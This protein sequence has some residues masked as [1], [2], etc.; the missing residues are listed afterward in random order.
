MKLEI[1]E[2]FE[3]QAEEI[4]LL[5]AMDK[6]GAARKWLKKLCETIKPLRQFPRM[7]R[8][9]PEYGQDF[10]REII[11]GNY[12]VIYILLAEKIVVASVWHGKRQLPDQD[13]SLFGFL[14]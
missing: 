2:R 13:V 11:Y 7:G 4:A 6:P 5:I 9:V 14:N 8:P 12:R 10:I 3:N 1:T